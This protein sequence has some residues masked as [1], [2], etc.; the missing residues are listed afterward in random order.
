[1]V[2]SIK[3]LVHRLTGLRQNQVATLP[4]TPV[5]IITLSENRLVKVRVTGESMFGVQASVSNRSGHPLKVRI[6][7]GTHFVSSGRFQNMVARKEYEFDLGRRTT[8]HISVATSC[9]NAK[10][11]A[12]S[13]RD[14]FVG[15]ARA[16]EEL[17]RFLQAAVHEDALTT[18]VGVWAITD[19]CNREML[20]SRLRARGIYRG[21]DQ[22][23]RSSSPLAAPAPELPAIA[24]VP[25]ISEEQIDRAAVLLSV[26][27]IPHRLK[28]QRVAR[29]LVAC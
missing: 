5:E 18:Q 27:G 4:D 3:A 17:N 20:L 21:T 22:L 15:I 26:L 16:S 13:S 1:M 28:A 19:G 6:L 7:L 14:Q 23:Y 24:T 8:Q 10:L 2:D 29:E 12:P 25:A 9:M 11:R